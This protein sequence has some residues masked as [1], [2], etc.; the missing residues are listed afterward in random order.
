MFFINRDCCM[1]LK[2]LFLCL[3]SV[4]AWAGNVSVTSSN[5]IS[6][7][8]SANA[9]DTLFFAAGT[10]SIPYS[11]GAKNRI[12][13]SNSGTAS[14]PIVVYAEGHASAVLDFNF[15]EYTYV[16]DSY[17]LYVTGS[18]WDFHGIAVTRAGYQGA[19]VIGSHNS[20]TDCA[21]Y[22][23][24]NSGLEIN[25]GGSYTTVTRTDA[26]RNYDPKKGGSMA[27]GFASKQTQGPGNVFIDCR[28]WENSDD[29]YDTYDSP[30]S[31]I[32]IDGWAFRNGI[33]VFN[34]PNTDFSGNGNGFKLGGN[35]KQA[36]NR[37]TRCIAFDNP[38]KGFDQNNNTGGIIIENSISYRNGINYGMGGTLNNGQKH[39]FYNNI[40]FANK[41]TDSYGS[42]K[43]T[44]HNSWDLGFTPSSSDFS[45]I[46]TSYATTK[47]LSNGSIPEHPFLHLKTSS[48]MIDAGI[49]IGYSFAGSAPDLGP[50]ETGML[51]SSSSVQ[52]SSSSVYSSSSTNSSS[53]AVS[54]SSSVLQSSSSVTL[55]ATLTKHGSGASSQ[56]LAVG[57]S[58]E[59]FYFSFENATSV[60]VTDLPDGIT[61]SIDN[62]LQTV[63]FSGIAKV[64]GTY[65]YTVTTIGGFPNASK[66]GKITITNGT[67][68]IKSPHF[69]LDFSVIPSL[70]R[71][72]AVVSFNVSSD[73]IAEWALIDVLGKV[74]KAGRISV[75][76]NKNSFVLDRAKSRSGVYYLHLKTPDGIH[77]QKVILE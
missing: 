16:Q 32:I 40:T 21:F 30:D 20:F 48:K 35:A 15:P 52:L 77:L 29:G 3:S 7:L 26:Y 43:T 31:V 6:A 73:G 12:T 42:S 65:D 5:F 45:S 10:Y 41:G 58:L 14:S 11:A 33:D 61:F 63:S 75:R 38:G 44:S 28:A 64:A 71:S 23:N 56:T 54:S 69:T 66:N 57:D 70:I 49:N 51:S 17:G 59:K 18:Y 19:Y 24:R 27:D 60:E 55:A 47:R 68:S 62:A 1:N 76:A 2:L 53:S 67:T 13:L 72:Q 9:G 34:D 25:K 4:I 22:E 37:C 50:F 74:N 36:N 46:D 39:V 8:Q